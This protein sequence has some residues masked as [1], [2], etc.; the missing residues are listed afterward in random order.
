MTI[1]RQPADFQVEEVLAPEYLA[2]VH[3]HDPAMTQDTGKPPVCVLYRVTKSSLTTPE[4]VSRLAKSLG[5]RS[6]DVEY[7]GLKDKHALTTQH[8]TVRVDSAARAAQLP[9]EVSPAGVA[10][11]R[12]ATS[13]H[14]DSPPAGSW[15]AAEQLG[16]IDEPIT[17]SA[18]HR[19]RFVIVVRDLSR[20]ASDEMERRAALLADPSAH[21]DDAALLITNYFGAQRFGSARHQQGF[22]ARHLMAGDFDGALRLAI[23][24]PARKDSGKTRDFTRLAANRWGDWAYLAEHLPRCPE[25]APIEALARGEDA[26]Q[27]F[28]RLP[29]YLQQLYVEAF[30]SHLWN[31]TVRR[32]VAM[33]ADERALSPQSMQTLPAAADGTPRLRVAR[34]PV[35]HTSDPFGDMAFLP[36][37]LVR[38]E[39]ER[40]EI[41][42][43]SP[44]TELVEPWARAAGQTL[45]A[46]GIKLEELKIPGLRRPFFGEALRAMF[47][48]AERFQLSHAEAD[49]LSGGGGRGEK[50]VAGM[51]SGRRQDTRRGKRALSFDL[52]RGAYATVVLR[53][54]G[55]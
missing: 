13:G 25:R 26:R 1:R 41:P 50:D 5:V 36:R 38:D 3:A 29:A 11:D 10:A 6:N 12:P 19:N 21:S 30:Q 35:I 8:M 2:R 55:Q 51:A 9:R 4:A 32:F 37:R 53:A 54:L 45:V 7:A 33:L 49:D 46:E 44:E 47:V 52:P 16:L 28:T 20:Q 24:T 23:A 43:L 48:R 14:P 22:I 15:V 27:A 40:L 31:D 34:S 17:A 39:D 18:I 42:V